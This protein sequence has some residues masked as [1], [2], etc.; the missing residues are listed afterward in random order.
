MRWLPVSSDPKVGQLALGMKPQSGLVT[1]PA[2]KKFLQAESMEFSPKL[3]GM[4]PFLSEDARPQEIRELKV[5][6]DKIRA[7]VVE[8]LFQQ[9][10]NKGFAAKGKMVGVYFTPPGTSLLQ[11]RL[12]VNSGL[13]IAEFKPSV[14]LS[15]GRIIDSCGAWIQGS[16]PSDRDINLSYDADKPNTPSTIDPA[17]AAAM[18][19]E[20]PNS[21]LYVFYFLV[22]S[23]SDVSAASVSMGAG[24]DYEFYPDSPVTP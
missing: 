8:G 6:N 1:F 2:G 12:R 24:R 17:V 20:I 4:L 13:P 19:K 14:T 3:E 15:D 10:V 18:V 9:I 7:A 5:D 23:G 16:L 21:A 22:P 11:V